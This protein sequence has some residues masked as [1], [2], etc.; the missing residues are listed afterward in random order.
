MS[1]VS[2]ANVVPSR[3]ML[4]TMQLPNI[5]RLS[6]DEKSR[7]KYISEY[8]KFE[9]ELRRHHIGTAE[10]TNTLGLKD[11]PADF[12]RKVP[13][14]SEPTKAE[15]E[16]A[17]QHPSR[18]RSAKKSTAGGIAAVLAAT[19]AQLT[20][21][22]TISALTATSS[23]K[24]GTVR[25]STLVP[26][27]LLRGNGAESRPPSAQTASAEVPPPKDSKELPPPVAAVPPSEAAEA[28]AAEAAP[29]STSRAPRFSTAA[30]QPSLLKKPTLDVK[31]SMT[32]PHIRSAPPP[33]KIFASTAAATVPARK[34]AAA[35][36]GN[37]VRWTRISP[38]QPPQPPAVAN[39][40]TTAEQTARVL[41]V[42][43][44]PPKQY[45]TS[46]DLDLSC[47]DLDWMRSGAAP[48]S[49]MTTI[50]NY[51]DTP[52]GISPSTKINSPRS[53]ITLLE[54]GVSLKDWI[55]SDTDSS[56]AGSAGVRLP[57][58]SAEQSARLCAELQQHRRAHL[59]AQ[60]KAAQEELEKSYLALCSRTSL[61][62]LLTCYQQVR[63]S[64]LH[65][66]ADLDEEE[67]A[68]L[69]TVVMQRQQRQ[70]RVFETNKI[71]MLRQ[72]QQAKELHV[73][74]EAAERRQQQ[75]EADAEE[76]RRRKVA[77]EMIARQLQQQ[78]LEA[79]RAERER[80]EEAVQVELQARMKKV[81]ARNAERLAARERQQ[82]ALRQE[83]EA[84]TAER[85]RRMERNTALLEEQAALR[86]QKRLEKEKKLEELRRAREAKMAEEQRLQVEKQLRAAQQRDEARR[87]AAEAEEA[88]RTAA[89]E[90][91]AQVEAQLQAFHARR[92][93]EAFQRAMAEAE[94]HKRLEETRAEAF[95]KEE[96]FKATIQE[97]LQ[98]HEERYR[99]TR[100]QQLA[101]LAWR[102][103]AEREELEDKAYAVLQL[104]R[105]AEFNKLHTV[106][107]LLQKHK[108]AS[109]V[110]RQR[111]LIC[112]QAMRDRERLREERDALKQ[113]L[114]SS[115]M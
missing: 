31:A 69:S 59:Q 57:S 20:S 23:A 82:R 73:R 30:S 44:E 4:N 112:E 115:V 48:P 72:V 10:T 38:S 35:P 25:L 5:P 100:A 39:A 81:E 87:R 36:R 49:R 71:R 84:Q 40:S 29:T 8:E 37:S 55:V 54:H 6:A 22:G 109:A 79:R 67:K 98:Q 53:A 102:C 103:E 62:Q 11:V 114:A 95:A 88:A 85:D 91:H 24:R 63:H 105:M 19:A 110:S 33:T 99:S 90:R 9:P 68:A 78:R 47:F 51:G 111:Q 61:Q 32:Q 7:S 74:L 50:T 89:L 93:E 76:E 3:S 14:L 12:D 83:R 45:V 58:D 77:E 18:S 15:I 65:P 64:F 96:K 17:R 28:P 113:Q 97:K 92:R 94:H 108:A 13:S 42:L 66:D 52:G 101:E 106:A 21:N 107:D 43:L 41:C 46:L 104:H 60:Q 70:R 75:A 26:Q 27:P 56:I 86:Q 2:V 16:F 34:S 1:H 80:R